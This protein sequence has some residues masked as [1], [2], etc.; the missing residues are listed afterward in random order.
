MGKFFKNIADINIQI[1]TFFLFIF[2][3]IMKRNH[4]VNKTEQSILFLELCIQTFIISSNIHK[5]PEQFRH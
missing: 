3:F 2:C 1:V 5:D 4:S